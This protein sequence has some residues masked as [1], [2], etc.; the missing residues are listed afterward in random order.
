MY[1]FDK[2]VSQIAVLKLWKIST[3]FTQ[4]KYIAYQ[5]L[6]VDK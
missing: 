5:R 1:N 2:S 3:M 4:R 6:S